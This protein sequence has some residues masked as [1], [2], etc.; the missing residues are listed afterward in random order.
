MNKNNEF[1]EN[2]L[3]DE[4]KKGKRWMQVDKEDSG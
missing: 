1:K 3:T 2:D 4:A